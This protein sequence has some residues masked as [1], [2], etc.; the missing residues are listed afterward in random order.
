MG[1]NRF[2]LGH[3]K[4]VAL[5]LDRLKELSGGQWWVIFKPRSK[6]GEAHRRLQFEWFRQIAEF[7]GVSAATARSQCK[8]RHGVPILCREHADYSA[9]WHALESSLSYEDLV[10]YVDKYQFP[11][12]REFT[13]KHFIE[14]YMEI[15]RYYVEQGLELYS[16][17][18]EI[19][20][21]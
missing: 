17:N 5:A 20:L 12:T 18:E 3:S 15:K 19:L 9:A 11:V 1:K 16:I 2:F 10:R 14:F 6:V 21:G 7:E 8:I 13:K 4:G